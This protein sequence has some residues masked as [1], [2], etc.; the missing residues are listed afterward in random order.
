MCPFRYQLAELASGEIYQ[1]IH[2]TMA[3]HV[4]HVGPEK[5]SGWGRKA[6]EVQVIFFPGIWSCSLLI[7]CWKAVGQFWETGWDGGKAARI[8]VPNSHLSFLLRWVSGEAQEVIQRH[9]V[10]PCVNYILLSPYPIIEPLVGWGDCSQPR[11]LR[12]LRRCNSYKIFI[13]S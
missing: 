1:W 12:L 4:D 10:W 6:C 2:R 8:I 7:H 13:T 9:L 3:S 5:L 11:T